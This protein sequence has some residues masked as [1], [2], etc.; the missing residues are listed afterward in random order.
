LKSTTVCTHECIGLTCCPPPSDKSRLPRTPAG[1]V[2]ERIKR[3]ASSTPSRRGVGGRLSNNS[4]SKWLLL[5]R[6][7]GW[8]EVVGVDE[9][10]V[11]LIKFE[12]NQVRLDAFL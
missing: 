4:I 2:S 7:K 10:N 9:R 1:R 6:R 12:I 11:V 5:W 3:D 8:K